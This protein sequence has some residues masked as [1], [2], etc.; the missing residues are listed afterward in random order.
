MDA[1]LTIPKVKTQT[2]DL[3]Y[4]HS[5]PQMKQNQIHL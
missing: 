2:Y 5:D 1:S 3:E 4:T